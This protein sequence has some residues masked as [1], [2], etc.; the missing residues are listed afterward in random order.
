MIFE[1]LQ[2][3]GPFFELLPE[4]WQEGIVPVWDRYSKS[5]DLWVLREQGNIVAG[6]IVFREMPPD[7]YCFVNQARELLESGSWYL[8]FIWVIPEQRGRGLGSLWLKELRKQYPDRRF[9]LT[10]EEE[11]LQKFY[12]QNGFELVGVSEHPREWLFTSKE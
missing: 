5:A 9:W 7:L 10:T 12:E 4:D 2:Q 3:A 6:G 1:Q 8:G 11:G